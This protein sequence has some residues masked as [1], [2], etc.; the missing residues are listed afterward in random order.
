MAGHTLVLQR[1]TGPGTVFVHD[2]A[3]DFIACELARSKVL[4]ADTDSLM[5]FDASVDFSAAWAGGLRRAVLGGEGLFLWV[6]PGFPT[7]KL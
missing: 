1:V 6:Y 2:A 4:R 3:G 5:W 7:L